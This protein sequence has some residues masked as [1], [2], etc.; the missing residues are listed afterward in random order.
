MEKLTASFLFLRR[1][2]PRVLERD[3][4]REPLPSYQ[5]VDFWRR[6]EENRTAPPDVLEAIR[7]RVVE[8]SAPAGTLTK[9]YGEAA[10]P[11]DARTRRERDAAGIKNVAS[12]LRALLM[13]SRGVVPVNLAREATESLDRLLQALEESAA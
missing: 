7:Q 10:F 13:E 6:A 12:R 3:G 11:T 8:H 1:K 2:A 9:A 5:S 4:V